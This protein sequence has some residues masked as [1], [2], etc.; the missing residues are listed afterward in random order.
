MDGHDSAL[1]FPPM[2][3]V[4]F[5]QNASLVP[6]FLVVATVEDS[7]GELVSVLPSTSQ[8]IPRQGSDG[9]SRA[10]RSLRVRGRIFSVD[11]ALSNGCP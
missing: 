3:L 10:S 9:I 8:Q 6:N 1:C 4:G 2:A 7:F 11:S 5:P